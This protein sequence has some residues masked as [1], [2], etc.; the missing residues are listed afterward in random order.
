MSTRHEKRCR[1]ASETGGA[2]RAAGRHETD[3]E[4]ERAKSERRRSSLG[5]SCRS[6]S[7]FCVRHSCSCCHSPFVPSSLAHSRS[8]ARSLAPLWLCS[9][10][11]STLLSAYRGV[12]LSTALGAPLPR[13]WHHSFALALALLLPRV[14]AL[15]PRSPL[16][17]R[18]LL[19][20]CVVP[21]WRLPLRLV[22]LAAMT[23]SRL[24]PAS[25]TSA[26]RTRSAASSEAPLSRPP[27]R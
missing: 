4:R 13:D 1:R 15:L 16:L 19:R 11:H 21:P 26:T 12:L 8:R 23:S 5:R 14:P 10:L 22:G 9:V 27:S 24:R 20:A 25:A 2:E 6:S 3:R 17:H 18:R 7:C